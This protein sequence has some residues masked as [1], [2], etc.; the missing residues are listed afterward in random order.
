MIAG[1]GHLKGR[2]RVDDALCTFL[3]THTFSLD[4]ISTHTPAYRDLRS[5][6]SRASPVLFLILSSVACPLY[7]CLMSRRLPPTSNGNVGGFS[8]HLSCSVGTETG[9]SGY[10][11]VPPAICRAV[12]L[13]IPCCKIFQQGVGQRTERHG[14]GPRDVLK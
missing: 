7:W 9:D 5:T 10:T 8:L 14:C 3:F 1:G 11:V 13:K 6:F 2:S 4:L 12:V